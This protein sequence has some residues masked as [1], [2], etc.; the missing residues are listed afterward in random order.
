MSKEK[1]GADKAKC[2]YCENWVYVYIHSDGDCEC[3]NCYKWF[4]P[5]EIQK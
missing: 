3:P 1:V 2:T 5:T 4:I